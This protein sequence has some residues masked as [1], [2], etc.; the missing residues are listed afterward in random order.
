[1][2]VLDGA[3]ACSGGAG[4]GHDVQGEGDGIWWRVDSDGGSS[5]RAQQGPAATGGAGRWA[6]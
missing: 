5:V 3:R 6:R 2:A 1:M 4:Q